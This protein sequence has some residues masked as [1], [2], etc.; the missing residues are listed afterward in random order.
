MLKRREVIKTYIIS[1]SHSLN[2]IDKQFVD[3]SE[4]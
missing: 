2:V 4:N 3:E 1:M